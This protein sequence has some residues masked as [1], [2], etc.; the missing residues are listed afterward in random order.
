MSSCHWLL[1]LAALEACL[2]L[3][4]LLLAV[5]GRRRPAVLGCPRPAVLGWPLPAQLFLVAGQ[6]S[7][8]AV[9]GQAGSLG[10]FRIRLYGGWLALVAGGR[11]GV[12]APDLAL[13]V[14]E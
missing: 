9:A 7:S 1:L 2:L 10:Y 4:G 14:E 13:L 12:V 11:V 8:L 5:S 3:A 6:A